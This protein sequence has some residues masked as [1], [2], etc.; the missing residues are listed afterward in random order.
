MIRFG[1]TALAVTLTC[2]CLMA[3]PDKKEQ[4][5]AAALNIKVGNI[6][7]NEGGAGVGLK[8]RFEVVDGFV[9]VFAL[10]AVGARKLSID[11]AHRVVV[12]GGRTILFFF[13]RLR[14]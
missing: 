4:D 3:Q 6:L 13:V 5:R 14:H 2:S 10:V 1:K 7:R 12:K 9:D 8:H 11:A